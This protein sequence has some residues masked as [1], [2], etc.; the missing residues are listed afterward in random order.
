MERNGGF[1]LIG[2]INIKAALHFRI[3]QYIE[4]EIPLFTHRS[5]MIE[6]KDVDKFI[7]FIVVD[8]NF[9]RVTCILFSLKRMGP[10]VAGP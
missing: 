4:A 1:I 10:P 3:L 7:D 2:F 6:A 5:Q 9:T 8:V